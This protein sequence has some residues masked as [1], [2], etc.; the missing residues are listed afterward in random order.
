MLW[1]VMNATGWSDLL[2]VRLL[3]FRDVRLPFSSSDRVVWR[4][5]QARHMLA[6]MSSG[7]GT[8]QRRVAPVQAGLGEEFGMNDIVVRGKGRRR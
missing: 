8:A 4:F 6:G 5:V 7:D 1:G 2:P 3:R